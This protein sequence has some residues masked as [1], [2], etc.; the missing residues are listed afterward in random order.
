MQ[1]AHRLVH[2]R[3]VWALR[4]KRSA[5]IGRPSERKV[6]AIKKKRSSVVDRPSER[7]ASAI[8]KKSSQIV[9]KEGDE[10]VEDRE[11]TR[12]LWKGVEWARR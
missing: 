3:G 6:L 4:K 2:Q 5:I 9:A 11:E 8:R 7:R 1:P 10:R 12:V